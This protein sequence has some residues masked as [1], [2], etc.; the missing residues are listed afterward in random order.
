MVKVSTTSVVV[1]TAPLACA[2]FC[3]LLLLPLLELPPVVKDVA[4]GVFESA[5]FKIV[6]VC[7]KVHGQSVMVNVVASVIVYV[8]PLVVNTVGLGQ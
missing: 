4:A 8:A 7:V 3:P 2:P 1:T 5:V 6:L